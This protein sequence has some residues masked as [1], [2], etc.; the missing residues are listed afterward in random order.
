MI[1]PAAF[2][3]RAGTIQSLH[4]TMVFEDQARFEAFIGDWWETTE[5]KR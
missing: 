5:L 1:R 4:E 2:N 3:E